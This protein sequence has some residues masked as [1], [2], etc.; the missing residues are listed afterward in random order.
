MTYKGHSRKKA[1]YGQGTEQEEGCLRTRDI[2]GRRMFTDKGQS[3]KK[4]VNGQRT[5][6]SNQCIKTD[7]KLFVFTNKLQ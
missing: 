7:L 2:A 4:V 6:D 1:V 3:R 5:S